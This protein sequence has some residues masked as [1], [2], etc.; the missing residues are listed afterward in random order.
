MAGR[1]RGAPHFPLPCGVLMGVCPVLDLMLCPGNTTVG[2]ARPTS[3]P[4]PPRGREG[5]IQR[6]KDSV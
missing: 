3:P 6:T 4:C 2:T 5:L 1:G